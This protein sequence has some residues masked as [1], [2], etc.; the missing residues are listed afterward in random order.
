MHSCQSLIPKTGKPKNKVERVGV[1]SATQKSP[2]KTPQSRRIPP[3]THHAFTTRKRPKIA[4]PLVKI[5]VFPRQNISLQNGHT[6]S[7]L[8]P[9]K[10]IRE[11]RDTLGASEVVLPNPA[12][13]T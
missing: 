10:P 13:Q 5:T 11:S 1:F 8:S 12:P 2:R 6:S 7:R 3:Q 9:S 4:K